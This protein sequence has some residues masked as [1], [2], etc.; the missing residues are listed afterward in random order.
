M[1]NFG[2][3][4]QKGLLTRECGVERADH[5]EDRPGDDHTEVGDAHERNHNIANANSLEYWAHLPHFHGTFNTTT[6]CCTVLL[7]MAH[8]FA[9]IAQ[10]LLP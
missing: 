4:Q 9:S 6:M 8:P 1:N 10:Q 2:I 5:V 7:Q 3:W